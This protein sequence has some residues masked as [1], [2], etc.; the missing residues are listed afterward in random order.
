MLD[1]IIEIRDEYCVYYRPSSQQTNH[2]VRTKLRN[3]RPPSDRDQDANLEEYEIIISRADIDE[4]ER[5]TLMSRLAD[6]GS[7]LAMNF[8]GDRFYLQRGHQL[9]LD[10]AK[11]WY[12]R[13]ASNGSLLALTNLA[14]ISTMRGDTKQA[15]E[16]FDQ[17]SRMN[18]APAMYSLGIAYAYGEL[19]EADLSRSGELLEGA[20]GMGFLSA[21]RELRVLELRGRFGVVMWF[22]ALL[23]IFPLM[24]KLADAKKRGAWP[25]KV[26][27]W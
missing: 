11:G 15:V 21:E 20:A 13:A 17:A 3:N 26:G 16:M 22:R 4:T 9:D 23:A 1:V 5:M 18:Y 27:D 19:I 24:S 6:N 14:I 10:T 2:G 12:E 7:I 25:E 8:M